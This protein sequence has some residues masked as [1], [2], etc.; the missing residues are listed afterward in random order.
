MMIM[1]PP[2]RLHGCARTLASSEDVGSGVSGSI[3]GAG[4]R[5]SSLALATLAAR[6]KE[7]FELCWIREPDMLAIEVQPAR[8]V[9]LGQYLQK[10]A[11]EQA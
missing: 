2:R 5:N 11:P 10:Q 8:A 4:T 6:L 9:C 7:A 1:R 3:A